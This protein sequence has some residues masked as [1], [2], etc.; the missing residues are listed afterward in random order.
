MVHALVTGLVFKKN[1]TTTEAIGKQW[2]LTGAQGRSQ[3]QGSKSY[4]LPESN[5]S[6]A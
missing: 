3:R 4:V 6:C 5:S 2:Q 1:K